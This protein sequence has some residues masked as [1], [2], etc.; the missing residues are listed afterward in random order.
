[1]KTEYRSTAGDMA[2]NRRNTVAGT[3][4]CDNV[5]QGSTGTTASMRTEKIYKEIFPIKLFP[6][7]EKKSPRN[8]RGVSISRCCEARTVDG[9]AGHGVPRGVILHQRFTAEKFV[10]SP[11]RK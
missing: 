1:M 6:K 3:A 8:S 2:D 4:R 9:P 7:I 11:Y 10:H 5:V